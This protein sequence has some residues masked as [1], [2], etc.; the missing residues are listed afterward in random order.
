VARSARIKTLADDRRRLEEENVRYRE[1]LEEEV[2][3]RGHALRE[4]EER[5][6]AVVEN[7][8]EGI[9]VVQDDLIRFANPSAAALCGYPLDVLLRTPF[10]QAVHPKDAAIIEERYASRLRGEPVPDVYTF[11][12]RRGDGEW[13]CFE[14]RPVSFEWDGRPATSTSARRTEGRRRVRDGNK[15]ARAEVR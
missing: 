4:S 11:R 5:H 9:V 12:I 13:R 3:R 6:R 2:E 1:H 7:A 10:L 8:V 15:K 14:L